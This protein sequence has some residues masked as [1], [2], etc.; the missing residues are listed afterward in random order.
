MGLYEI[1]LVLLPDME[2]EEHEEILN[3]LKETIV[4]NDGTVGK[5]LNWQKRRLA[6]EIE[7]QIEGHYYLVYFSGQ[8]TIIPEIEHFFRVNDTVL[9]FIIV[10]IEE[11]EYESAIVEEEEVVVEEEVVEE[12]TL[13]TGDL[14]SVSEP[15]Y[16]DQDEVGT[17]ESVNSEDEPEEKTEA[18]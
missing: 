1:M 14:S 15:N 12:E 6:Y 3:N 16:T 18:E 5:V 8:G 4:K 2:A 13:E 9:R 7:N 10:R 11:D 17:D